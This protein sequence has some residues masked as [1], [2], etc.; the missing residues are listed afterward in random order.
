MDS[1][2]MD[3]LFVKYSAI[4]MS[5]SILARCYLTPERYPVPEASVDEVYLQNCADD[6]SYQ[7][8]KDDV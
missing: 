8:Y 7:E 6:H 5:N 4:S 2:K 1:T 3:P